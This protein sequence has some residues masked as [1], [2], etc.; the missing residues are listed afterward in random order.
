MFDIRNQE[1]RISAVRAR[2]STERATA[3][4]Q[5][6]I[7]V[8]QTRKAALVGTLAWGVRK[9]LPVVQPLL[10]IVVRKRAGKALSGGLIQVLSIGA[11]AFGVWRTFRSTGSTR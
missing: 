5:L 6:R 3:A 2:V 4:S 11:L 7:I 10:S 8:P 9:A 1:K